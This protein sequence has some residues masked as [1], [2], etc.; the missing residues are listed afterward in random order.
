MSKEGKHPLPKLGASDMINFSDTSN[1]V[2]TR[3]NGET[4]V[5]DGPAT[6][7]VIE[8]KGGRVRI[9]IRALRTTKILRGEIVNQP[10]RVK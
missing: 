9:G 8:T 10:P 7:E 4:I 1:L 6:F 5:V 2:L 3:S